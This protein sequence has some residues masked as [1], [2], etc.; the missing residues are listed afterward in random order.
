MKLKRKISLFLATSL[1]LSALT[2][3]S[4]NE[5]NENV[6]TKNEGS[7][8][9]LNGKERTTITYWDAF[10]DTML[11]DS[12]TEGLIEA[13]LPVDIEVNRTNHNNMT[14]VA[15][16]L[17]ESKIPDVFW[18]SEPSA[19]INS[20]ELTRTIPREM[21]E[22]YAPSFL[23]LYDT[24]PSIYTSIIDMENQD[25]FFALNGATGQA[26]AVACSMYADFYRY[27]W[28]QA[29]D[30]D[31]GVEITQI[32]D[33]FYV[34]NSGLTLETFE[35]VMKGFTFGDPDGNG[36]DDTKGASFEYYDGMNRFDLLYSGFGMV[37]GVNESNGA[38]E[39]FY[40]TENYKEFSIWFA[41]MFSKG[42]FDEEMFQQDRTDRWEKVNQ[43]EVGY[44]LES[45]IAL[46]SWAFGRPPLSVFDENP[47]ATFLITPGLSD[48]QGQGTI[49]KNAMP[50]F[51]RLCYISKDVDDEKLAL[52]L[53]VLEYCNFGEDNLS[54]WYGEEG[55]DW[56]FDD[57][58]GVKVLNNLEIA[59][60]G[61]RVFTMNV[62]V[63]ELF[64]AVNTEPLF[65]AGGDHWLDDGIWRENDREQ[66]QYKL[67]LYSES[68]YEEM[69]TL[70]ASDCNAIH[71]KYFQDWVV[72]GL[73][74]EASWDD[75]L[76]ELEDAGYNLM[77][78]E[79][80]H[81]MPLDEML[82]N[83]TN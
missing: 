28:I 75:M 62:Q 30:I 33:Q 21:V 20:L 9:T 35:E 3:C 82:L 34:A 13:K 73:D 63:G 12:Y 25:E 81:V 38:A 83:L 22:E 24:Y 39:Q 74:V 56:A 11:S 61:A 16:L 44:F 52:I 51:G 49:I 6:S 54:M 23:E 2:S 79:L 4:S 5:N 31:L 15:N 10:C 42:Y 70:Y 50:T 17:T 76:Q 57:N 71:Q 47:D 58:G 55:V 53:Q 68:D 32:S 7:S 26:A 64:E 29:L 59:E 67:D 1:M 18:I 43:G 77:M 66:Y 48:N 65:L 69:I 46:N 78:S 72:Q 41:D 40:A 80:D 27:D 60:N 8:E 19:Y 45:S 14:Q 37:G 36:L